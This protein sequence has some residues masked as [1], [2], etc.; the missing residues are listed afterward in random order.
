MVEDEKMDF[1]TS[2]VNKDWEHDQTGYTCTPVP[3]LCSL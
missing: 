1:E 3:E 2:Y